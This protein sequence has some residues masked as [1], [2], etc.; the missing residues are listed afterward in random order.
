MKKQHEMDKALDELINLTQK[1]ILVVIAGLLVGYG[2]ANGL[3]EDLILK[4]I[5]E[6]KQ[7]VK[8]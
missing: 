3:T 8:E 7:N 1:Q 2:L 6:I 4:S 5:N